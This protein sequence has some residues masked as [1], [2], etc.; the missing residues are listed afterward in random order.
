MGIFQLKLMGIIALKFAHRGELFISHLKQV[1][2]YALHRGYFAKALP[3]TFRKPAYFIPALFVLGLVIGGLLSQFSTVIRSIYLGVLFLYL[4]LVGISSKGESFFLV[5]RGIV[6][7]HL[8]Y[9][10]FFIKGLIS[11]KLKEG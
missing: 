10:V 4:I 2:S 9:G 7:T 6:L 8:V 11:S 5:I 1:K 3:E